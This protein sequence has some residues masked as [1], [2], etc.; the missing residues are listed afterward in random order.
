MFGYI[1]LIIGVLNV[2]W[3]IYSLVTGRSKVI[4]IVLL[5]VGLAM[6]YFGYRME[7]SAP[8]PPPMMGGKRYRW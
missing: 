6:V 7:F 3:Q 2:G 5:V 8:V 1:L 4:P